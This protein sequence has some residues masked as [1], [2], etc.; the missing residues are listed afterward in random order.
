MPFDREETLKK[1]EKLARQGRLASAIAEYLRVVEA[2]P[3][4]WATA[5]TLGDLYVR[6]ADPA[7]AAAQ[8]TRAADHFISDGFYS[9]AAAICKKILKL[10][11]DDEQAQLRLADMSQR[12]GLLADARACLQA[13][14]ARRRQ[15]GDRAGVAEIV[16]RL[17]AVDPND[18][19][20]RLAAARTQAETG[21][22]GGAA[23]AF[24]SI[25]DDLV[26]R[27]ERLS[28]ALDALREA[29]RLNPDDCA[30]R[31]LLARM[32]A[33]AGDFAGARG[34]L[35]RDTAAD[36]P[37]LLSTLLRAELTG[38]RTGELRELARRL[39]AH[40]S[41]ERDAVADLA[42]SVAGTQP[43]AAFAL[44]DAA[45]HD[46][47]AAGDVREAVRMLEGFVTRVPNHVP[48]LQKLLQVCADGGLE[49]AM[50][51]VRARLADAYLDAGLGADAGTIAEDLVAREPWERAHL[52]RYRRAL[53]MQKVP[54]PDMVIA[55]RLSGQA[56]F[57]AIDGSV[58]AAP[59]EPDGA[60]SGAGAAAASDGP[61]PGPRE[62]H[63][64]RPVSGAGPRADLPSSPPAR[65]T[66][67][68]PDE[69]SGEVDIT[70]ELGDLAERAEGGD[71]RAEAGGETLADAFQQLRQQTTRG[72]GTDDGALHMALARAYLDMGR[73]DR[74]L[75]PLTEAA[76][77]PRHRFEAASLIGGIYRQQGDAARAAEWLE[78]ALQVPAST[79]EQGRA[80]L[81]DLGTIVEAA[82]DVPRAL[83]IFM[84]LQAEA[85]DYRD[86][87]ERVARLAA[88]GTDAQG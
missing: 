7:S 43:D 54:D 88:V 64:A 9:K 51:E 71:H 79:V 74:A 46:A 67:G 16:I 11:P 26:E 47:V 56:P 78:R 15:R 58:E 59:A 6:G 36:D 62:A 29:V 13:V 69:G 22:R 44:L 82:G 32:A 75:E 1:A 86:V 12:L 23:A 25:H 57:T 65:P 40:G 14:A 42:W 83:A 81:Y 73:T 21:D 19:D 3:G 41:G 18:F 38:G 37:A 17:G 84:E 49:S 4:D 61:P 72:S 87:A 52:D 24:R 76:R 31:A 39:L 33:D 80:V 8:Y 34:Y 66:A 68:R 28:E 63:G 30:G 35:D 55:E 45:A 70:S 60:C 10:N 5:N 48:A 2:D 50:I 85:G 20:A 77:S 53:V 27:Q